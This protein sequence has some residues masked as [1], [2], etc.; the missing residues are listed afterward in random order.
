MVEEG[1]AG[2]RTTR[3]RSKLDETDLASFLPQRSTGNSLESPIPTE[4]EPK[5]SSPT[6]PSPPWDRRGSRRSP[7][8]SIKY[9]PSRPLF[10]LLA[11]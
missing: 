9:V 5:L 3:Q 1:V 4:R 7:S 8:R 11:S 10:L 2:L 6:P